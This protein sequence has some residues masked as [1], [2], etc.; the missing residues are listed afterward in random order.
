MELYV[1]TSTCVSRSLKQIKNRVQVLKSTLSYWEAI[2]E[3]AVDT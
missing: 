2:M 3:G 1:L